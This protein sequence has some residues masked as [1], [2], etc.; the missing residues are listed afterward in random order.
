[1]KQSTHTISRKLGVIIHALRLTEKEK[2]KY[3]YSLLPNRPALFGPLNNQTMDR[4]ADAPISP[5]KIKP[6]AYSKLPYISAPA[7]PDIILRRPTGYTGENRATYRKT[8][9]S[10]LSITAAVQALAPPSIAERNKPAAGSTHPRFLRQKSVLVEEL[11]KL[12]EEQ[13][14]EPSMQVWKHNAKDG[15]D[16][17]G[18]N[19]KSVGETPLL[20]RVDSLQNSKSL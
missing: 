13:E 7:D 19:G 9:V 1:M 5:V 12:V 10:D 17:L 8:R 16:Q 3:Y 14:K 6:I 20:A 15:Y 4:N 2:G 11:C 18:P